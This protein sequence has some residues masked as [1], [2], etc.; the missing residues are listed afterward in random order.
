MFKEISTQQITRM[1]TTISWKID[2]WNHPCNNIIF[3][4]HIYSKFPCKYLYIFYNQPPIS[5]F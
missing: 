2:K 1:P 4:N 3:S 5:T